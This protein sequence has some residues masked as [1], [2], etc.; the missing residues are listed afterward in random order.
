VHERF[1]AALNE[2]VVPAG[3]DAQAILY[4]PN[5]E[6]ERDIVE[7][8]RKVSGK[9]SAS[10]FDLDRLGEHVRH[11]LELLGRILALVE[12]I[13]PEQDAKLQTLSPPMVKSCHVISRK[14]L[15]PSSAGP[16]CREL[17]HRLATIRPSCGRSAAL[18]RKS[19]IVKPSASIQSL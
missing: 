19:S 8:L 12:P 6:E 7:A 13:T 18:R 9:Y 11:D 4:Q 17:I 15:G 5:Q 14:Y 1:L 3:D 2:G 10:D 16:S